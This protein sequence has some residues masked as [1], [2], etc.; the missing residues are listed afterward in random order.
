MN[1]NDM[2]TRPASHAKSSGWVL[3]EG[4][5]SRMR[6]DPHIPTMA[7][8]TDAQYP[9]PERTL[10]C[11][12]GTL[13]PS[14]LHP[15]I[16]IVGGDDDKPGAIQTID[17]ALTALKTVA[18]LCADICEVWG[19]ARTFL[20]DENGVILPP[21]LN[22]RRFV[23]GYQGCRV[24]KV[25]REGSPIVDGVRRLPV[26][27]DCWWTHTVQSFNVL[28]VATW[29]SFAAI[30]DL[31]AKMEG[32]AKPWGVVPARRG[33]QFV[34]KGPVVCND[35]DLAWD[36]LP[37]MSV[38]WASASNVVLLPLRLEGEGFSKLLPGSMW[39]V[40]T[41]ITKMKFALEIAKQ[42]CPW[43]DRHKVRL[44]CNGIPVSDPELTPMKCPT[45]VGAPS[46]RPVPGTSLSLYVLPLEFTVDL[47][48]D[49]E[50]EAGTGAGTPGSKLESG[51]GTESGTPGTEAATPGSA[52][53]VGTPGAGARAGVGSPE[54]AS[55]QVAANAEEEWWKLSVTL[56]QM[57]RRLERAMTRM[58]LETADEAV[59]QTVKE[60]TAGAAALLKQTLERLTEML[61][62]QMNLSCVAAGESAEAGEAEAGGTEA[63]VGGTEAEAEV[64]GT[65][66]EAETTVVEAEAAV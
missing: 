16:T 35:A 51:A 42:W 31:Q 32:H 46:V 53:S 17:I 25:H 24:F 14:K 1:D 43:G 9:P 54:I 18:D 30:L 62:Q 4:W 58:K 15:L 20:T 6:A 27:T 34:H 48:G 41:P 66:A 33:P 40:C 55:P 44:C 2:K 5:T 8:E 10:V 61:G 3:A 52:T 45:R 11:R 57:G 63:E 22:L 19:P 12:H 47:C 64:G 21:D 65:E 59:G 56:T 37:D 29:D 7:D 36:V 38:G 39:L 26:V 49:G 50:P 23:L 60:C 13:L 28:P